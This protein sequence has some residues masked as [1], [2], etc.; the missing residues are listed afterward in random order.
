[1]Q[2]GKNKHLTVYYNNFKNVKLVDKLLIQWYDKSEA[3]YFVLF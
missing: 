1:M 3:I 2:K